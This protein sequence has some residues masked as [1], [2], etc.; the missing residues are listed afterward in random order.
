MIELQ[1]N[2]LIRFSNHCSKGIVSSVNAQPRSYEIT[3]ENGKILNRN[4]RHIR[5]SL[6]K[7][8]VLPESGVEEFEI[9]D[10]TARCQEGQKCPR[11]S[12]RTEC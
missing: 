10:V 1:F 3:S 5:D 12:R 9:P 2:A 6:E 7:V 8:N 11:E 4:R